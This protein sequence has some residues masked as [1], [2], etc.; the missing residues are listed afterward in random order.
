MMMAQNTSDA[1]Q[2]GTADAAAADSAAGAASAAAAA[3]TTNPSN[4]SPEPFMSPSAVP[5]DLQKFVETAEMAL[6]HEAKLAVETPSAAA[7][8]ASSGSSLVTEAHDDDDDDDDV[9]GNKPGKGAKTTE[10]DTTD[11]GAAADSA[12]AKSTAAGEDEP[13]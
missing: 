1:E 5:S 10:P 8:L 4:N 11:E 6:D 3:A 2:A 7:V 9:D 12:E 13:A